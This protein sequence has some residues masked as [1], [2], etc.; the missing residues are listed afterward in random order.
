VI[1][2]AG[3]SIN[4]TAT[5]KISAPIH[6]A[7][8]GSNVDTARIPAPS[9]TCAP[10]RHQLKK[11][12]SVLKIDLHTEQRQRFFTTMDQG[13]VAPQV[14]QFLITMDPI[15]GDGIQLKVTRTFI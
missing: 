15:K 3:H 5:P 4:A 10:R 14:G 6:H 7:G 12:I 1:T 9:A 8:R 13:T 11:K 2:L